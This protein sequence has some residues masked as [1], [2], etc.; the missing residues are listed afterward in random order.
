MMERAG[1]L[2]ELGRTKVAL[3]DLLESTDPTAATHLR[4]DAYLLF[5]SCNARGDMRQFATSANAIDPGR[6][7]SRL[8]VD[9]PRGG[10]ASLDSP[11]LDSTLISSGRRKVDEKPTEPFCQY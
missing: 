4:T 8:V 11:T 10:G 6:I 2:Y 9:S 5:E 1:Q 7:S 3:A